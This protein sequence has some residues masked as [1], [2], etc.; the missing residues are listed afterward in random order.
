MSRSWEIAAVRYRVEQIIVQA[1]LLQNDKTVS[2]IRSTQ[3]D[4]MR[5]CTV[6]G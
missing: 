1:S 6:D 3:F 2:E 4:A 5:L